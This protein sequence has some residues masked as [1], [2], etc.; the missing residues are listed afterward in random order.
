MC[1]FYRFCDLK[2]YVCH[3]I[4]WP[5]Q[6]TTGV[7]QHLGGSPFFCMKSKKNVK[8]QLNTILETCN[9]LTLNF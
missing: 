4:A 5:I 6:L 8:D 3:I 2:K 9:K 1:N 7:N